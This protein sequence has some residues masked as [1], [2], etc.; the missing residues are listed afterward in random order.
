VIVGIDCS[1]V[2]DR[3]TG[4]GNYVHNLLLKLAEIDERNVYKLFFY[5]LRHLDRA[6]AAQY[7]FTYRETIMLRTPKPF[8]DFLWFRLKFP[9]IE[10]FTGEVDIFHSDFYSP[11][12]RKGKSI[13]T[14]YDMS[15]FA[16][17]E[18]QT[19]TVQGWR[20]RVVESCQ[21]ASKIITISNFSKSEILKYVDM[22]EEKIKVIYP[23]VDFKKKVV[24]MDEDGV[25]RKYKLSKEYILFV[26]TIEPRKNLENLARA[27]KLLRENGTYR[28][29]YDLVIVGK[30]GW[31]YEAFFKTLGDLNIGDGV[32]FLGYIPD[33]EL[34][35]VYRRALLFVYPSIYEGF[36]LPVLEAMANEVPVI[37]SNSSSLYEIA[38]GGAALL[39][40]PHKYKEIYE[41]IEGVLR[42]SELRSRLIKEGKKQVQRFSWIK[43]AEE[44]LE[45]YKETH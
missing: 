38:G 44:T 39:I 4:V 23:G 24:N 7:D 27:F 2:L 21:R 40:N 18:L 16:Y 36:G 43:T 5:S 33:N 31:K 9:S 45:I 15:F 19:R 11:L 20:N 29:K 30:L 35:I 13:I 41:A 25:L 26:G 28:N 22:P 8:L 42:D 17:P 14:I 37:T 12:V 6:K 10:F 34:S 32:K 3:K 1:S